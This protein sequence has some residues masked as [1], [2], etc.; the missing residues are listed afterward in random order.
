MFSTLDLLFGLAGLAVPAAITL[1]C[2]MLVAPGSRRD[3][4]AEAT[5]ADADVQVGNAGTKH[6]VAAE[7]VLESR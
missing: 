6:T 5:P 2:W 7:P 1:A 4:A 3:E